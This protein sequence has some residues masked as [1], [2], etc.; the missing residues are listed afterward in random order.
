MCSFCNPLPSQNAAIVEA[1]TG[2]KFGIDEIKR[3]GERILTMKRLF[4]VKM[5]LKPANDKLPAI[6][7][8]KFQEGGSAG[9]SPDFDKLKRLFY[10]YRDWNF[11]TGLPSEKKMEYLGLKGIQ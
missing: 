6:L 2:L 11:E 5:G 7:L 8:R 3:Y 9:K 1:A 4:N 10:E